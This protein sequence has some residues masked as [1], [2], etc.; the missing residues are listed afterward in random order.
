M[1]SDEE[2]CSSQ[3][4]RCVNDEEQIT[5]LPFALRCYHRAIIPRLECPE[6]DF[7]GVVCVD[8]TGQMQDQGCSQYVRNCEDGVLSPVTTLNPEY[9]CKNHTIVRKDEC[10]TQTCDFVG[11]R[12]VDE[13][14]KW[15][16]ND[17]TSFTITCTNGMSNGIEKVVSSMACR[18]GTLVP[19]SDCSCEPITYECNWSG[20]RCTDWMGVPQTDMCTTH[21]EA[22]VNHHITSPLTVP[23]DMAC[24]NSQL[25]P[26]SQCAI[27]PDGKCSFCGMVCSTEDRV[28]IN[29]A[30]TEYW[31][32]CYMGMASET[33]PVPDGVLCYQGVFVPP[34]QC[35][36]PPVAPRC[37]I[38]PTGPTGP[39]SP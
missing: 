31:I 36:I 33:H 24:L 34:S 5:N 37:P 9:S 27:Y 35:P 8:S 1:G 38:S 13:T 23:S 39:C 26:S 17:C 29:D 18:N 15:Y 22:C 10:A 32:Q 14:G 3:V 25:I 21:Y 28:I 7:P 12:C 16:Q 19:K 11:T 6:C 2:R 30:C 4:A 20:I